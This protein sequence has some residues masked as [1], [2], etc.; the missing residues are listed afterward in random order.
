MPVLP[1]LFS[2]NSLKDM[3]RVDKG[4]YYADF[5]NLYSKIDEFDKFFKTWKVSYNML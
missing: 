4:G 5:G 1:Q 2:L 3:T